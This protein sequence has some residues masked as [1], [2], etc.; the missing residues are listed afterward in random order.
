MSKGSPYGL[1]KGERR[2]IDRHLDYLDQ[3]P[4][5]GR[6]EATIAGAARLATGLRDASSIGMLAIAIVPIAVAVVVGGA[7]TDVSTVMLLLGFLFGAAMMGV[8]VIVSRG[9]AAAAEA[10]RAVVEHR[11]EVARSARSALADRSSRPGLFQRVRRHRRDA[12][13]GHWE[14]IRCLGKRPGRDA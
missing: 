11:L 5:S 10:A 8:V 4:I 6:E 12:R 14:A 1:S 7:S 2:R 3:R 13:T 9:Q